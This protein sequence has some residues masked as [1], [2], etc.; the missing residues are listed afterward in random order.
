MPTLQRIPAA[1]G[2]P[3]SWLLLVREDEADDAAR[4]ALE[5][6]LPPDGATEGTL[7]LREGS[8][9]RRFEFE[10]CES[11]PIMK[12]RVKSPGVIH[13]SLKKVVMKALT[14]LWELTAQGAG[15]YSFEVLDLAGDPRT[16]VQTYLTIRLEA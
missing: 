8:A 2:L 6:L 9:A 12:W 5:D 13:V 10:I 7:E 15:D 1:D 14:E 11:C 16:P 4:E 3:V